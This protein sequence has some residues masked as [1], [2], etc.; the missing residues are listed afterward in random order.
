MD[1][2]GNGDLLVI[3]QMLIVNIGGI[4]IAF[5]MLGCG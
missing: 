2:Q 5:L 4:E 3:A 1:D